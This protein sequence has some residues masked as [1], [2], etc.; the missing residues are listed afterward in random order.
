MSVN[1]TR[2]INRRLVG[3]ASSTPGNAGQIGPIKTPYIAKG[4]TSTPTLGQQSYGGGSCG[5]VFKT[6]E[7]SCG[8]KV[9]CQFPFV[10]FGG[11]LICRAA[12]VN[13]IVAPS[14]SEVA[15]SWG[16]RGDAATTA[17]QVSG[18]TGW[19]IP[20]S[21]QLQN[22]G[23]TCRTYWDSY[24]PGAYWSDTRSNHVYAVPVSMDSGA[25]LGRPAFYQFIAHRVR[26]FRCV[27]Y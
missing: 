5:G 3:T 4:T 26:A 8:V 19:F 14:S 21:A 20:T 6:K 18:C 1:R 9:F 10:N 15:R 22:P 11:N 13:W 2:N 17:Q 7:S 25:T 16:S 24:Q 12:S 27:T 23:F